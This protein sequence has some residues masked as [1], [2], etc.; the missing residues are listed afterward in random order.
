MNAAYTWRQL[1]ATDLASICLRRKK[2]FV[3]QGIRS[4][5]CHRHWIHNFL[6][7]SQLLVL[8]LNSEKIRCLPVYPPSLTGSQLKQTFKQICKFLLIWGIRGHP[9]SFSKTCEISKGRITIPHSFVY[10]FFWVMHF[11]QT[12]WK[13]H[14]VSSHIFADSRVYTWRCT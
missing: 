11:L 4:G 9:K 14:F 3:K 10:F 8:H 7:L 13:Y 6:P 1:Y 12:C 2:R 5:V